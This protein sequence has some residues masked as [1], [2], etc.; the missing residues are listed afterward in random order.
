M[1]NASQGGFR[2]KRSLSG[3][4]GPTIKLYNVATGDAT[5]IFTG[6]A[7]KLNNTGYVGA[8]T[9]QGDT[10][11]VGVMDG[12]EA[13]WDGE[14]MRKGNYLPAATA[15]G[16]NLTRTSVIRVIE[17][18]DA[19][20][21]I[22]ADDGVTATTEAAHRAF[23]GENCSITINAGVT[24]TGQ[25]EQALDISTHVATALQ[26]RIVG[27]ASLPGGQDWAASRVKYDIKFHQTHLA[28]AGV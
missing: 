8:V 2:Y 27:L 4:T 26:C 13:Y 7:V 25:S 16:T 20:F 15:Y 10:N 14:N 24:T 23:I 1:P 21:E 19:V 9:A 22:D 5:A 17:A 12:V 11:I 28:G 6:D 3:A 18:T